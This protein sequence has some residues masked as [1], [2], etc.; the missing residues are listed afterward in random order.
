MT[1]ATRIAVLK[2]GLL[3]QVGTPEQLYFQPDNLFVAGF[4]GSPAMNFVPGV[5]KGTAEQVTLDA[6]SL[7]VVFPPQRSKRLA[8]YAGLEVQLGIRPED[9]YASD[10]V[11]A[12]VNGAR[13]NARVDVTEMLGSETLLHLD[14]DLNRLLAKVDP[15]TRARPGHDIQV[16]LDI[17]R[18][19]IFDTRT[20]KA[21]DRIEVPAELQ[22]SA[23]ARLT[24]VQA[25]ESVDQ[26]VSA[27]SQ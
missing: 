14:I 9:I 16:T 24:A 12:H 26:A 8:A 11:P 6:G 2:D 5:L 20:E 27:T 10:L 13:V 18:L 21:I 25:P 19:H 1:M 15:R 4:I 17:D 22:E 23:A 3:H 7:Q